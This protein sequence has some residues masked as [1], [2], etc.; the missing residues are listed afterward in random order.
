ME[1]IPEY[2]SVSDLVGGVGLSVSWAFTN[3]FTLACSSLRTSS[4][5]PLNIADAKS[6]MNH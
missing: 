5:R 3:G 6:K 2:L 1:A 4:I